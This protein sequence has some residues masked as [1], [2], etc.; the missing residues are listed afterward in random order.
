VGEDANIQ[1]HDNQRFEQEIRPLIINDLRSGVKHSGCHHCW[2][3]E[4]LNHK[5]MRLVWNSRISREAV[6]TAKKNQDVLDIEL[7]LGNKC[8]LRCIMCGPYASSQWDVALQK[9]PKKL[10]RWQIA[11]GDREEWWEQPG[12][13]EWL[14][15]HLATALR[16]DITGGEPLLLPQTLE[17][18]QHIIDLDRG[19]AIHVQ[20]NTNFTRVSDAIIDKLS[21]IAK[22]SLVISLEG[23]GEKNDYLR[24]PAQ[25]ID[26]ETNLA[27]VKQRLPRAYIGVNHT[28]QHTS[29][30]CLPE[31]AYWCY[32][33]NLM[34]HLTTVQGMRPLD[35]RGV[36]PRDMTRFLIW[37]Q[38]FSW[39][40]YLTNLQSEPV[41]Q[42][43]QS[44]AKI[45]F[46]R[47]QYDNFRDYITVID[48][49]NN[50]K[51]DEIFCP[52]AI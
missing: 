43:V 26:I 35:M 10:S 11:N 30:Y 17:I 49:L 46:D 28:L 3:E 47:E 52:A 44:L 13:M 23:T 32:D 45:Q 24:Y 5:S 21:Q 42:Y 25:W 4:S 19:D 39:P 18:L 9:N 2:Q 16:I 51:Y 37:T 31:L 48:E 7:S 36:P 34:L 1:W 33:N 27:K 12:F 40:N 38:E 22:V 8:N 50:M 29:V 15:Q 41:M 20:F 14:K 6:E